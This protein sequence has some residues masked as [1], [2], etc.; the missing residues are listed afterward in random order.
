MGEFRAVVEDAHERG[1][2]DLVGRC[3]ELLE[4]AIR[5]SDELVENLVSVSFVE[6]VGPWDDSK[7]DFIA[8][9]PVGLREEALRQRRWKPR[10]GR[11]RL[12]SRL[13]RRYR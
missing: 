1:D 9:W 10:R 4:E 5:S 7:L 3:L 13:R 6:S 11:W 8:T 12:L 2:H